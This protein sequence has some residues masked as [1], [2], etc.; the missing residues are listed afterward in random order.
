MLSNKYDRVRENIH[1]L[2]HERT[3]A[4]AHTYTQ[5]AHSIR[6][7][8]K[9]SLYIHA[10]MRYFGLYV[11]YAYMWVY[12]AVPHILVY[13]IFIILIYG[14]HILNVWLVRNMTLCTLTPHTD[15]YIPIHTYVCMY[16]FLCVFTYIHTYMLCY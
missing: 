7:R 4:R 11:L 1:T 9:Y 13:I 12:C 15:I 8:L 10:R 14:V 16:V 5:H 3:R 2:V 6:E